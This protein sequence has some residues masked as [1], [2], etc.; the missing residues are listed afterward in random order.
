MKAKK[1]KVEL[2]TETE[3]ID[4]TQLIQKVEWS[5]AYN[6]ACRKL[7]F[8]VLAS[9]YDKSIPKVNIRCG[10]MIRL[11]EEDKEL[12]RGYVQS[13]DISYNSNSINYMALDGGTYVLRN[14]LVYN[15]KNMSA[16]EIASKVCKDLGIP[17]GN[18]AK[19]GE[20]MDKK[21]FGKG[22]Y[23]IIM[24]G[25]TYAATKTKKKYMCVMNKGS[26]DVIEKGSIVLD[27]SFENGSN[28]LE[29]DYSEDITNMINKVKVYNGDEQFVKEISNSEDMKLYGVFSKVLKLEDGK[30]INAEAQKTLKKIERKASIEGFGDTTCRTGYGV[31]VKDAY[32]GL[33][34]LF[35]IDED[36][37]TWENGIYKIKLTLAFENMMHEVDAEDK[38]TES[39]GG[40]NMS[41]NDVIGKEVN[42]EFT[43]Y[44]PSNDPMQ[45]GFK[46]ANG[47]TLDPKENTCAAPKDVAF[48]SYVKVLN[49]NTKYD[50]TSYRVNDRGGAI[51]V[52]NGVYKIDLLM[53]NRKEAYAFGR[54]KGKAI[55]G[56]LGSSGLS[57]S[58]NASDK[59]KKAVDFAKTKIGGPY[60]W[61]GNGPK[62]YDCS[63]LTCAAY[64][65][66]GISINRTA[67]TQ[68][69]NGRSVS[70]SQLTTGDLVFFDTKGNG[71]ITHVGIMEDSTT[72]IH[73]SSPKNGIKRDKITSSYYSSRFKGAR[74]IV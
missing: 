55:I 63:G 13:R 74:R 71:K 8:S 65:H 54:R 57:S 32:T 51:K 2:V 34:G 56:E 22:G 1:I 20:K 46:A 50:N 52:V 29:S 12:F 68:I 48:N 53:S 35:Y 18:L 39:T 36:T 25:Y 59:A 28:I 66:V 21:F 67:A 9:P 26:L 6:Q 69:H 38:E 42:A 64:K 30:D 19:T 5:G 45:G 49:T 33:V 70:K 72:F 37:H 10:H 14:E 23:D 47:E 31:K 15:I 61:G 7:T 4:M 43:A 62:G 41:G 17:A 73:A 40:S 44:Y 58:S 3:N 11:L 60:V 16:E 27:L 24:T